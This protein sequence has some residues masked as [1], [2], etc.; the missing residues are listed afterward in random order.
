MAA[1]TTAPDASVGV[2]PSPRGS[3]WPREAPAPSARLELKVLRV[4]HRIESNQIKSN[5]IKFNHSFS[6][7]VIIVVP[8][9]NAATYCAAASHSQLVNKLN[10]QFFKVFKKRRSKEGEGRPALLLAA[11][12]LTIHRDENG[13]EPS[14]RRRSRRNMFNIRQHSARNFSEWFTDKR[15]RGQRQRLSFEWK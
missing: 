7:V 8:S 12:F 9:S 10:Q 13:G 15:R 11:L 4:N 3:T 2:R 5:S 14:R 6:R 1:E